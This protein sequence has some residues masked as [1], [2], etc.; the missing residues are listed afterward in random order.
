MGWVIF[1]VFFSACF[2]WGVTHS[3]NDRIVDIVFK[4]KEKD[5]WPEVDKNIFDEIKLPIQINGK[6]REIITVKK[7]LILQECEIKVKESQKLKKFFD[8]KKILKTIFVKN[9]IINYLI[10]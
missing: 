9:K 7:D 2:T 6:T 5:N 8:G 10:K 3:E 4:S 1:Y